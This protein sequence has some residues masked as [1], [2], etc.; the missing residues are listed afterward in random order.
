MD[1][2]L[3]ILLRRFA[4]T[5]NA[6]DAVELSTA[7]VRSENQAPVSIWVFTADWELGMVGSHYENSFQLCL[8]EKAA[9]QAALRWLTIY[10]EEGNWFVPPTSKQAPASHLIEQ[11]KY[12]IENNNLGQAENILSLLDER[13]PEVSLRVDF[14]ELQE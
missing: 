6:E 10:Q 7:L 8:T 11:L 3:R 9:Y 4:V 5:R 1:E 14:K 2:H 12:T 13:L